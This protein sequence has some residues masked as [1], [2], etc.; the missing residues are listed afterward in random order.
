METNN[1]VQEYAQA[2]TQENSSLDS[3]DSV[4]PEQSIDTSA[5]EAI[6]S[7]KPQEKPQVEETQQE[8]PSEQLVADATISDE[9]NLESSNVETENVSTDS[10]EDASG[11]EDIVDEDDFIKAKTEGKF[12]SWEEVLEA[13]EA[14]QQ[15]QI[16]FENETSEAIYNLLLEGKVNEVV[17]ALSTKQFAENIN[18]QSDE[19]VLKAYIKI[20]NPEFDDD[21]IEAEYSEKYQID[22]YQFDESKLK[23]EQKKLTQRIKSDV[24]EAKEF[25]EGLAQEIK[26]PEL[27]RQTQSAQESFPEDAEYEALIQEQ[28]SMFLQSLDGVEK[29]VTALPFQWKDDKANIAINGKF[30]I[31]AQ[32]LLKYRSSAEDIETYNV[33]R[34]YQDGKYL[35][36]KMVRDLYVVDNF[37][38]ILTS[39]ISQAV[40]QTRLEMLKQSKNIQTEQEAIGTFRPNAADEEK[41][42][43]D[44][45]FMGHLKRQ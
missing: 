16:K 42:L 4:A 44:Q 37:D 5:Y 41:N 20:N 22:E 32:E 19:D 33:N 21:D 35:G 28:R 24:Q 12:S 7:G 3:V 34:Y 40:N 14:Q 29:R 1:I 26:L 9:T 11:L 27:N 2:Q 39:A 30:E 10:Q 31:P 8:I 15:A 23:R 18:T 6:L 36:D 38:K 17:D 45:L 25:F 13:L 43:F